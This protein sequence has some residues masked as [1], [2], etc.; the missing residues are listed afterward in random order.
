MQRL[1]LS[2]F[3]CVEVSDLHMGW[4]DA[5]ALDENREFQIRAAKRYSSQCG[6]CSRAE[7]RGERRKEKKKHVS[8]FS[9]VYFIHYSSCYMNLCR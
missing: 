7:G 4:E 5:R 3:C 8:N 6:D 1:S 9:M 2:L